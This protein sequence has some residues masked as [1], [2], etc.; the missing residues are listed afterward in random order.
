MREN[1]R[2][3]RGRKFLGAYR[4]F[5]ANYLR[6]VRESHNGDLAIRQIAAERSGA[7]GTAHRRELS[8]THANNRNVLA[9]M[10]A[11]N[12]ISYSS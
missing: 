8:E 12:S 4:I 1:S 2:S 11:I 9:N 3:L 6:N 10:G 5:G 7:R